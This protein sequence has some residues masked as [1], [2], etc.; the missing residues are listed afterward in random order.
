MLF[1]EGE[2]F[3]DFSVSFFEDLQSFLIDIVVYF[4]FDEVL[5]F[6]VLFSKKPVKLINF[7]NKCPDFLDM[8]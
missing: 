2:D 8:T 1:L 6:L 4:I 7:S 5:D 3:N